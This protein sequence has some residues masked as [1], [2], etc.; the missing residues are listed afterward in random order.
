MPVPPVARTERIA[1]LG[2]PGDCCAAGFQ[3]GLRR[4][5]VNL[6]PSDHASPRLLHPQERTCAETA[7]PAAWCHRAFIRGVGRVAFGRDTGGGGDDYGVGVSR[8]MCRGLINCPPEAASRPGDC[9]D[10]LSLAR[11]SRT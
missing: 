10:R 3:S 4:L 11:R 1:H 9:P 2:G 8:L 5:W 6:R 7:T